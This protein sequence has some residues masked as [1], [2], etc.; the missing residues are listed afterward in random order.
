[1]QRLAT[2]SKV[3]I[4]LSFLHDFYVNFILDQEV[5]SNQSRLDNSYR[6]RRDLAE[7][8]EEMVSTK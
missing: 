5:N 2:D 7:K 4:Y 3:H 1:M 8:M 6:Y